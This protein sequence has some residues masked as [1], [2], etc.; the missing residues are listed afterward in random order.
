MQAFAGYSNGGIVFF[1]DMDHADGQIPDN[2]GNLVQ[3]TPVPKISL[4]FA[5]ACARGRAAAA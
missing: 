1:Q 3:K 4:S 2:N 5:P